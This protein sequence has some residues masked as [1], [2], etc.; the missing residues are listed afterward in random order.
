[1]SPNV[2]VYSWWDTNILKSYLSR[3]KRSNNISLTGEHRGSEQVPIFSCNHLVMAIRPILVSFE[4]LF[5]A[6]Q[7]CPSACQEF[8][9]LFLLSPWFIGS[10]KVR[11][12]VSTKMYS[13]IIV[14]HGI[15]TDSRCIS[16]VCLLPS[17]I[18]Y[19]VANTAVH[20]AINQGKI[21]YNSI[22]WNYKDAPDKVTGLP[23]PLY[24]AVWIILFYTAVPAMLTASPP[25]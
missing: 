15:I 13:C 22:M 4:D 17:I 2:D 21:S 20:Q 9:K 16:W 3:A 10:N 11:Y 6:P 18:L 7:P 14:K 23:A 19:T 25:C 12:A 1:M 5:D 8:L 24:S